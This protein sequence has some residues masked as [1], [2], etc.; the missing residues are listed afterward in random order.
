MTTET[1]MNMAIF[2]SL[3]LIMVILS[4]MRTILTVKASAR[5]ASIINATSYTLYSAIVKL[6]TGQEM[7]YILAVTFVTNLVGVYIA[8]AIISKMTKDKLWIFN[9]TVNGNKCDVNTVIEMLKDAKIEYLYNEL[10]G[11]KFHSLQIFSN[12]QQES[13]M[14]TGILER[15]NIKYYAIETK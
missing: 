15:Y 10:S 4:T 14:I 7:W 13:D 2:F 12:T 9:A 11:Q 5:I 6:M 8:K 3:Q 1:I